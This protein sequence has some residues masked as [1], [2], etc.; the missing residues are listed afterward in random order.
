MKNRS[1]AVALAAIGLSTALALAGCGSS[2]DETDAAVTSQSE[3][4][5]P[6]ADEAEADDLQT[7]NDSTPDV[8]QEATP[9]APAPTESQSEGSGELEVDKGLLSVEVTL[10][11]ELISLGEDTPPTE[12]DLKEAI[13]EEGSDVEVTLNDDGS[14]TYRMSR[15]EYNQILEDIRDST[16]EYIQEVIDE[17]PGVFESVTFSDDIRDFEMVVDRQAFESNMGAQFV[18]IGLAFQGIFYQAFADIPVGDQYVV[19]RTIDSSTGEEFYTY[20]SREEQ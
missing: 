10:P 18:Y 3:T 15:G 13:A 19:V 17:S 12:E 8:E 1:K 14:A 6:E 11:A 20:D 9:S 5:T 16:G 7:P 4:S 2:S